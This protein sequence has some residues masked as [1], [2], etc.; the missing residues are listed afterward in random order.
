[1]SRAADN[2]LEEL[3]LVVRV[4]KQWTARVRLEKETLS[5]LTDLT[6][7]RTRKS[8]QQDSRFC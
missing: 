5:K 8:S 3:R 1:M 2:R 6:Y 4:L 7:Q